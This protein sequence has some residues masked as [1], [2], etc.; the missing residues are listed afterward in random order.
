MR[1]LGIQNLKQVFDSVGMSFLGR[2][3]LPIKETSWLAFGR[4]VDGMVQEYPADEDDSNEVDYTKWATESYNKGKDFAYNG[5]Q[6]NTPLTDEY[7]QKAY[8]ITR[9]QLMLGGRRL[10]KVMRHI[11]GEK[12]RIDE[13]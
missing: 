10:A 9:Y 7:K 6:Y 2:A 11:F 12:E 13:L 4:D 1:D 3:E 5:F 8:E